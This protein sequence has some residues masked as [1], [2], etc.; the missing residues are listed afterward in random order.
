MFC[1]SLRNLTGY[2][3][4]AVFIVLLYTQGILFTHEETLDILE[5]TGL[6][7]W[8]SQKKKGVNA[9]VRSIFRFYSI[10][11]VVHHK[12]LFYKENSNDIYRSMGVI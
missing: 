8:V 7:F 11:F 2:P 9:S 5:C 12:R 4:T 6:Y 3:R 10:H 1:C